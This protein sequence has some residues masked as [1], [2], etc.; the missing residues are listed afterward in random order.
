MDPDYAGRTRFAR[1]IV[2]GALTIGRVAGLLGTGIV[3]VRT[4]YIV[5]QQ[6]A[7][8]FLRPVFIG[9]ELLMRARVTDWNLEDGRLSVDIEV[10]NQ[11]NRRV[12]VGTASLVVFSVAR[13][14]E[15]EGAPAVRAV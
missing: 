10:R 2:P 15:V 12:L 13:Q 8:Q 11:R 7:A 14:A 4:H 6:F 9:D 3:N 5:T 1:P